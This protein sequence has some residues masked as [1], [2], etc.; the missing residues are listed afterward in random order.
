MIVDF[1]KEAI[2]AQDRARTTLA[3]HGV[4]IVAPSAAE[5]AKIRSEMMST[6]DEDARGLKL[7]PDLVAKTKVA[8]QVTN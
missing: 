6:Q 3:E 7:D 2:E 8:L 4:K 5:L 1:R